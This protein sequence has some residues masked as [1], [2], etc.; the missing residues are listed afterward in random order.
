M[1]YPVTLVAEQGVV[2]ITVNMSSRLGYLALKKGRLRPGEYYAEDGDVHPRY[3]SLPGSNDELPRQELRFTAVN[4]VEMVF[5]AN[6]A[7]T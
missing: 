4:F 3:I 5:E 1:T 2:N 7:L 6:K